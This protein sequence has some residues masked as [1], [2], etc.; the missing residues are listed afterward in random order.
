MTQPFF[1]E[2]TVRTLASNHIFMRGEQYSEGG[3]VSDLTVEGETYGAI[4]Y[5]KH[6]Y[7]VKIWRKGD[8]VKNSCSC[9]YYGKG[10]CRHVVAVMLTVLRQGQTHGDFKWYDGGLQ[11]S[12]SRPE[13]GKSP[14]A[15]RTPAP[16]DVQGQATLA[17]QIM[18]SPVKTLSP[19]TSLVDAYLFIL[20]H[21]FRHVPVTSEDKKL[22]G[23]LS[24]RDLLRAAAGITTAP[25]S[26][27]ARI[28]RDLMKTTV[29]TASPETEIRQIAR[30]FFE[31]RVG[32]MPILDASERV[33][34]IITRSDVLRT[35]VNSAPI[36]LWL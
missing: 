23:I 2:S 15:G 3:A 20:D 21:R 18:N 16:S 24:D 35:L 17:K 28:I 5:G 6:N 10:I 25:S 12:G 27:S 7:L 11:V 34:G 4:V 26:G 9:S 33:V 29:L 30:V 36:D 32:A 1:D 22:V 8:D 14:S 13:R 31:E 19:E